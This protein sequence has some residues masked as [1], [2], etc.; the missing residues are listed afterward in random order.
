M[1]EPN[2]LREAWGQAFTLTLGTVRFRLS[3]ARP[4]KLTSVDPQPKIWKRL[5]WVFVALLLVV[6]PY[7][8]GWIIGVSLIPAL[9]AWAVWAWVKRITRDR[10]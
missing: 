10:A 6:N 2:T 1:S 5:V 4:R 7:V 3:Q 9:I 8:L